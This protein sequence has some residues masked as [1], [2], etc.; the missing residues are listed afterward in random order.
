MPVTFLKKVENSS[1]ANFVL[2][3][4]STG[5]S[6]NIQS[7]S[8]ASIGSITIPVCINSEQYELNHFSL[9][10]NSNGN[11]WYIWVDGQDVKYSD[12]D[13]YSSSANAI[14]GLAGKA[15]NNLIFQLPNETSIL[16][17]IDTD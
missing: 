13:Q 14:P 11:T 16:G 2:T 10:N 15:G 4:H 17:E 6:Y 12:N 5:N 7:G 9:K 1:K 3:D 8:T